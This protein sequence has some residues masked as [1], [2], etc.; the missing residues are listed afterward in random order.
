MQRRIESLKGQVKENTSLFTNLR[1]SPEQKINVLNGEL[2]VANTRA[3]KFLEELK[4]QQK[5]VND[6]HDRILSLERYS[7]D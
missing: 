3:D 4:K 6:T 1:Q 2:H 5:K 7:R